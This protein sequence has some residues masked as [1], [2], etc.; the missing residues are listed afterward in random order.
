MGQLA[1]EAR[2]R[3]P[4]ACSP[5]L[6]VPK[7]CDDGCGGLNVSTNL[8]RTGRY[9][10]PTPFRQGAGQRVSERQVAVRIADITSAVCR[11][12]P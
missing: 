12:M 6:A 4:A 11:G 9:G 7:H 3:G 2:V 5:E 10:V 8:P 1:P